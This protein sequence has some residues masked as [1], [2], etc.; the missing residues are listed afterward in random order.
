M[1]ALPSCLVHKPTRRR[2][3][4]TSHRAPSG[5]GCHTGGQHPLHAPRLAGR[6]GPSPT[7]RVP[8]PTPGRPAPPHRFIADGA[9]ASTP[10]HTRPEPNTGRHPPPGPPT[11]WTIAETQARELA[12]RMARD[13]EADQIQ[14]HNP[15]V[16]EY[17]IRAS[18]HSMSR[19]T[20]AAQETAWL[21]Q[22][23]I[24]HF[25]TLRTD[26][27]RHYRARVRQWQMRDWLVRNAATDHE[28]TETVN[29]CE[30]TL[31]D[32]DLDGYLST[33]TRTAAG[34]TADSGYW[35]GGLYTAGN[36]APQAHSDVSNGSVFIDDGD[37]NSSYYSPASLSET[38]SEEH[39][40]PASAHA[41]PFH[42]N[43]QPAAPR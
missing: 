28:G 18:Y 43:P 9:D 30:S 1:A 36:G 33:G 32:T 19:Q 26:Q 38:M 34:P 24:G 39:T 3:D 27:E 7:V 29:G 35:G 40:D 23:H 21:L 37:S 41:G 12:Q 16:T 15:D 5:D 10:I 14:G 25:A 31:W 11:P 20:K 22:V 8:E 17:D 2:T 13:G 4:G 6:A 42:T